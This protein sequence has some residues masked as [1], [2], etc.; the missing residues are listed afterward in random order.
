MAAAGMPAV[1]VT[2]QSNLFAM[3]KFY[4]A[5]LARGHQ[6]HHRRRSARARG[7]R[8]PA[9]LA[10]HAA[11]PDPDRLPQR[12]AAREPRLSRRPAARRSA[13]SSAAGSQ[14]RASTGLIALSC[15]TEA[16][17]AARWSTAREADA[18][19]ALDYWLALLPDR[20]YIELQ[21]LG[22]PTRKATSPPPWPRRPPRRAGGR[23]QRRALP[24]S[25]ATSSRTRRA[26]ASTTARCSPIRP[27]RAATPPQQYLRTPAGDGAPVR[28]HPRGAGQ[29]ASRS[30]A[31]AASCS[32]LGAGALAALSGPRRHE[33]RG[34]PAQGGAAGLE[35]RLARHGRGAV[36]SRPIDAESTRSACRRELDVICQMGFAGYFLIVADFIRWATRERRA[37]RSGPRLR[38]RLAGGLQPAASPISIRSRYDLLFERFLNPERVSMPDFDV[39]FCM[40]GRDRVIDYVAGQVRPR[41][42][43]ADHHLR[44][45]G[46]QGRGAR[47]RPRA[48][49][50]LRL[51]RPD[52]QADS[53]R[54]RHHS[55]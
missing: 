9:A 37:G 47:R 22:R 52:R 8:A 29:L 12:H 31:A 33:H 53:L 55:R 26:S 49:H 51:R 48:R 27:R 23:D 13:R 32:K 11:V 25:R 6:A 46:G 2:D 28:R 15:A 4:R 43:L 5:A 42:R 17:S 45:H 54:A 44:H 50:D 10:H 36:R 14:P 19:R 38:R 7:R 18:E 3:V 35:Q 24:R 39:D 30:P 34:L 16:M 21:R 40:E 20:F 1:A 41:A